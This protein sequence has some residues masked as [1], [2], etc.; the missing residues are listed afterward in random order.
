MTFPQHPA[1]GKGYGG[2]PQ[3]APLSPG[4]D[5]DR[6][7]AAGRRRLPS[8]YS[9]H[10]PPP[11]GPSAHQAQK[12]ALPHPAELRRNC[13]AVPRFEIPVTHLHNIPFFWPLTPE[14]KPPT[15]RYTLR[16]VG[17]TAS[18]LTRAFEL[19]IAESMR[20]TP[21]VFHDLA[22]TGIPVGEPCVQSDWGSQ[23][24]VP[25]DAK[26]TPPFWANAGGTAAMSPTPPSPW[27]HFGLPAR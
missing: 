3:E 23:L 22:F 19:S 15:D 7:L 17:A 6:A 10:R 2:L 12:G 14:E 11:S 21:A 18:F 26:R 24:V 27:S 8:L 25:P 13:K 16:N 5:Q 9:Y 20:F 4:S 1:K